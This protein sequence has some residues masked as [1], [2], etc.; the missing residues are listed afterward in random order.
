LF[1]NLFTPLCSP[2]P[3]GYSGGSLPTPP[4][5][6]R[7]DRIEHP[8]ANI[9]VDGPAA[10]GKTT[11][12]L[13][14]AEEKNYRLVDT[15]AYYRALGLLAVRE[16]LELK[17]LSEPNPPEA[18]R[19]RVIEIAQ[20][21]KVEPG[22]IIEVEV[23]KPDSERSDREKF[24]KVTLNGED[25][26]AELH[27]RDTSQAASLVA[28]IKEVR[29]AINNAIKKEYLSNGGVV[30]VGRACAVE[31]ADCVNLNVFLD[32]SPEKRA[33]RRLHQYTGI[34]I[35]QIDTQSPDYQEYLREI[36][37]RDARDRD[38]LGIP[39]KKGPSIKFNTDL[40]EPD[41]LFNQVCMM[42]D[43]IEI[44]LE[45]RQGQEGDRE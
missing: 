41:I 6:L 16:G 17:E 4:D 1:S 42:A 25:V 39:S 38:R 27:N 23:K 12:A 37:E 15:G 22:E 8:R 14:M 3:D 21:M 24:L 26:T 11:L 35:D 36:Q 19:K 31:F 32:A 20:E 43:T 29:E 45:P 44:E 28:P 5:G 10:S 30:L 33:E 7:P 2:D 40:G 18:L 34:P 13:R 9:T